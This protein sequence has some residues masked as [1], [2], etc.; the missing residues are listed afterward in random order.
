MKF[1]GLKK[2]AE[3]LNENCDGHRDIISVYGREKKK[4]CGLEFERC[5]ANSLGKRA[6]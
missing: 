1:F 3:N 2:R 5:D 4:W 6:L